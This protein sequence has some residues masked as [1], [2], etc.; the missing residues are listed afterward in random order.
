MKRVSEHPSRRGLWVLPSSPQIGPT[1]ES[2]I[3]TAKGDVFP[4][5]HTPYEYYDLFLS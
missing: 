3:R 1:V 5:V 2:R 4:A